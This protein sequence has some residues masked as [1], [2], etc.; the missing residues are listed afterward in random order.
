MNM[1]RFFLKSFTLTML[2]GACSYALA[3]GIHQ[4]AKTGNYIVN[5]TDDETGQAVS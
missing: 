5:Y 1:T 3:A 4:D 2:A